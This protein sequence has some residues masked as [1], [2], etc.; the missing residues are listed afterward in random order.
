MSSITISFAKIV[1]ITIISSLHSSTILGK[2]GEHSS[3]EE[4]HSRRVWIFKVGL[5]RPGLLGYRGFWPHVSYP[6]RD[7]ILTCF[8]T[9]W[10][11]EPA[12][13]GVDDL[14]SY[15]LNMSRNIVLGGMGLKAFGLTDFRCLGGDGEH[16][17]GIF[18]CAEGYGFGAEGYGFGAFIARASRDSTSNNYLPQTRMDAP[19]GSLEIGVCVFEEMLICVQP[20]GMVCESS[21]HPTPKPYTLQM[22]GFLFCSKLRKPSGPLPGAV[23]ETSQA[24]SFP[25]RQT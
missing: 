19:N 17:V 5:Q 23:P 18:Q 4:R 9:I 6:L 2:V 13:L 3:K 8:P 7:L 15:K 16:G 10:Y 1:A 21:S 11:L 20:W 12:G 22:T 24:L 14:A 25:W